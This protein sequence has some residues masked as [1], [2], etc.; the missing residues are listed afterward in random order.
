MVIANADLVVPR[1]GGFTLESGRFGHL[2]VDR[3][4]PDV[5]FFGRPFP[6]I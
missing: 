5:R 6:E 1:V 2:P 4:I 3:G